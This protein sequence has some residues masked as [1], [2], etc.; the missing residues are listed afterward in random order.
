MRIEYRILWIDDSKEW[1]ESILEYIEAYLD[2]LGFTLR[3]DVIPKYEER[4]LFQ[5]DIVAVDYNLPEEEKGSNAI[6][7]IRNEKGIFTEILFYSFSGEGI[8]RKEITKNY[9]DGVYCASRENCLERLKLLIDTTIRKTQEINNL[10]GLVMA[11]TSELDNFVRDILL[12]KVKWTEADIADRHA[13]LR[14]RC[15]EKKEALKVQPP[16]LKDIV[17]FVH[18]H[19]HSS[20]CFES[21][22]KFVPKE[23]WDDIKMYPKEIIE[24][25]NFL[26]HGTELSSSSEKIIIEKT[27]P[28]GSTE[29]L[30]FTP[31]SF[32][33]LRLKI[34]NFRKKFEKLL[35]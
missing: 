24:K 28:D 27:K 20:F 21:L 12:K 33:K 13:A 6:K 16:L 5:Y 22:K 31:E 9:I 11:E 18:E 26:A 34:K 10:R 29:L 4:D 7:I 17:P 2:N 25:R 35:S 14:K 19:F 1:V 3:C 15:D 30:T 8:L 23:V 32:I